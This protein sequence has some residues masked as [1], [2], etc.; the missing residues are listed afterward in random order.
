[1]PQRPV[2]TVLTDLYTARKKVGD[3][4]ISMFLLNLA[5]IIETRKLRG[6][7]LPELRDRIH[8][9]QRDMPR[10][11]ALLDEAFYY[12]ERGYQAFPFQPL[13][14]DPGFVAWIVTMTV[15]ND[16]V[17][18][19]DRALRHPGETRV[20]GVPPSL[21]S[22]FRLE[23]DAKTAVEALPDSEHR[24]PVIVPVIIQYAERVSIEDDE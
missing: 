3:P 17:S 21:C 1:M 13:P 8:R 15:N 23:G 14:E 24:N 10:L 20:A 9:V 11:A 19:L 16:K 7:D 22:L 4:L 5:L 12:I 6:Y 18:R 2:E